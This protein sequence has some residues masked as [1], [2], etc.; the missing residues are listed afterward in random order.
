MERLGRATRAK[1]NTE[2]FC[3]ATITTTEPSRRPQP[4]G[5][6]HKR[7]HRGIV[8]RR[9]AVRWMGVR[10]SQP[11]RRNAEPRHRVAHA[12][13]IFRIVGRRPVDRGENPA[14]KR[15]SPHDKPRAGLV[16]LPAHQKKPPPST[17]PGGV[18]V[19]KC[20][21]VNRDTRNLPP[22]TAC[23]VPPN[24]GSRRQKNA[25]QLEGPGRRKL[26][27]HPHASSTTERRNVAAVAHQGRRTYCGCT[28]DAANRV[29]NMAMAPCDNPAETCANHSLITSYSPPWKIM[30]HRL[31]GRDPGQCGW[32]A[33][34]GRGLVSRADQT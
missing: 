15:V 16:V 24:E 22:T 6:P 5:W 1:K 34:T 13:P 4:P 23:A 20:L 11:R 28:P 8:R 10:A 18:R 21:P 25:A 2:C 14:T 33:H 9:V 17:R 27:N 30:A 7:A 19:A 12:T 32:G 26:S 3:H 31:E 29:S